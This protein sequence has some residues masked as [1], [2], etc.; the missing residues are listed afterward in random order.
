MPTAL[1]R[2]LTKC[3][4]QAAVQVGLVHWPGLE[5]EFAAMTL[6]SD[7][8]A[9]PAAAELPTETSAAAPASAELPMP[10]WANVRPMLLWMK[11]LC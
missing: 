6:G 7:A 8:A 1:R 5:A 2:L 10:H 3:A 11:P 4:L 9:A